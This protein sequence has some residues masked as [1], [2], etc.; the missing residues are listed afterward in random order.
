MTDRPEGRLGDVAR[1]D[2]PG[3]RVVLDVRPLQ[4]PDRAPLGATYLAELLRAYDEAPLPGELF[5][6]LLGS[7]L[8]DPTV[9]YP[10]LSVVGRRQLPPTRLLRSGSMT[11]D[12][13]LL[14]GAELRCRLACGTRRRRG[15]GLSRGRRG[16]TPDRIGPAG[17]RDAPGPRPVGA[18]RRVRPDDG[19][20]VRPATPGP[21]DARCGA[22]DRRQR[23][24]RAGGPPPA[25]RPA[26]PRA[27]HP[28]RGAGRLR[29]ADIGR[30][31]RG[32][33]PGCERGWVSRIAISCSVGGSMRGSTSRRS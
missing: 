21:A 1:P 11:V 29:G 24:D 5:A 9:A 4:T 32:R 17:G 28:V 31:A 27:D 13:F 3:V 6:M 16:I 30:R 18:A 12:P 22:G 15:C 7:D 2:V 33:R 14:R 19:Q 23:G 8:D 10:H 20:P 26:R 25:P